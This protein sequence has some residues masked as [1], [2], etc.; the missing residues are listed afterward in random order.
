MFFVFIFCF[1]NGTQL[2]PGVSLAHAFNFCL[3]MFHQS[4]KLIIEMIL[5]VARFLF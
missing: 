3:A 1:A 4:K 5:V 2:A